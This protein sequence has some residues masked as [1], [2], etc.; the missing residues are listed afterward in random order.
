MLDDITFR[1]KLK[2]TSPLKHYFFSFK[3]HLVLN[4]YANLSNERL[5]FSFES[6]SV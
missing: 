2:D 3:A 6:A 5:K 1:S 4:L